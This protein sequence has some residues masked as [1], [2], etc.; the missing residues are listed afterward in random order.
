M[1]APVRLLVCV[2]PNCDARGRGRQLLAQAQAALA[3]AFPDAL[4]EGR[5][6]ISTRACL[7][8]CTR[9]PVVRLEPSGE[10]F[11]DPDMDELVREIAREI[12]GVDKA[13]VRE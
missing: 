1:T 7:R 12:G 10:V 2:G 5:L 4:A 8:L 11:A 3:A 6:N 9:D 13:G